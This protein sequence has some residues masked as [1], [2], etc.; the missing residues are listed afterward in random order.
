MFSEAKRNYNMR[1]VYK[2][3][4]R[5]DYHLYTFSA[6]VFC[7]IC[8]KILSE[9]FSLPVRAIQIFALTFSKQP[10]EMRTVRY[11][12]LFCLAKLQSE[13]KRDIRPKKP[14]TNIVPVVTLTYSLSKICNRCRFSK[15]PIIAVAHTR[16]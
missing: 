9:L 6:Q 7:R 16:I 2:F 3:I 10:A 4:R 11:R 12:N 13:R 5:F 14:D 15:K 1:Q 8:F